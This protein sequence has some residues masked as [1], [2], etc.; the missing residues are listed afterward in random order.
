MRFLDFS[1]KVSAVDKVAIAEQ[2]KTCRGDILTMT[3]LAGSGHPGGSMS[4]IDTL[5]AVY[6]VANVSPSNINFPDR[7]MIFVSHGHVSPA[8]YSCLASF[9]FFPKDDAISLF[10]KAGSP[11]EGHIERLLAGVEWTSGNLG[12]GL[13]AAAG[14]AVAARIRGIEKDIYVFMGDGEQQKGQIAEARRFIKKYG[15]NNI[16]VIVDYNKLQI[17][18]NVDKVMGTLDISE[19]F[20]SDGWLVLEIDGHNFDDIF[21]ALLKAKSADF[22]VMIFAKT[23]MGKG[24]SFMENNNAYHGSALSIDNYK[25]AM[26]ELGF[27]NRLDYYR[28]LRSDFKHK[29]KLSINDEDVILNA[30]EAIIYSSDTMT[31]N[32]SAFG[33]AL[34]SI[35]TAN[36]KNGLLPPVAVFDCDLG[37]S[38][39]TAEVEKKFPNNYFQCGIAEHHAAVCA[40]AA[41][42]NGVVSFFADF[43]MFGVDEVYNQQR[44]NSINETNLKLVTTHVG[45]DV[46]EDGKTHM[47]IDYIS[48]LRNAFGF[49]ILVPADPNETDTIIRYAACN[50]GN[51]HIAMGRSKQPIITD[52]K[53]KAIFSQTN[54]EYGKPV[55]IREGEHLLLSYGTMLHRAVKV[56]EMA[57]EQ[58]VSLR[59][60]NISSPAFIQGLYL[61]DILKHRN[62]FVY[63]DHISSGGLFAT[64]TQEAAKA[65]ACVKIIPFGVERFAPS[66]S[67]D[68]V[69][70][71]MGLDVLSVTEKIVKA[72][73]G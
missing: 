21:G 5:L 48:L 65:G 6:S 22:P 52:D 3:T 28:K 11:Y 63:E 67:P 1:K 35:L 68:E 46:G 47:C 56:A 72:I 57:L 36:S 20:K 9:N 66:G 16:T 38:V 2:A 13:S 24:V 73:K 53:G 32:R 4:T 59:V 62:I 31:D 40:G 51:F 23:V 43:G 34:E 27:E 71:I 8:V 49:K 15:F 41:S 7:D 17:T 64:I 12:Q 18:G 50:K 45:L 39:K 44:L 54:F 60:V 29:D 19:S 14:A 33:K 69:L 61:S 70:K 42:V 10:R 26:S 37:P 25:L 55:T 30:G 58:G